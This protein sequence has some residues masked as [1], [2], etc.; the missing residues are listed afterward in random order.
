MVNLAK[1][2]FDRY[3]EYLGDSF[4]V[5]SEHI[6][7]P[8]LKER[9]RRWQLIREYMFLWNLDCL[10]IWGSDA[11]FSL[12][13]ANFRYVTALPSTMGRSLCVFPRKG[14]PVAF[15]GTP[16]DNY[17]SVCYKWVKNVRPFASAKDVIG[18]INDLGMAN[19]RIGFVG[20]MPHYWPFVL[21][22]NVW[23]DIQKGL[24]QA[25]F[26][27]S[28]AM[29]W[30]IQIIKSD[31]EIEFLRKAGQIASNVY[32]ALLTAMK[33]GVRE[34]EIFAEMLRAMVANGA[35]STGMILLDTGNP[36]FPHPKHPPVS[37]RPIKSGDMAIT[38]FHTKYAGFHTH[39]ERTVALGT[40]SEQAKDLF[41]VGLASYR[42]GME[43]MKPGNTLKDACAALRA[44]VREARVTFCECGFHSHGSTSGGFP[45]FNENEDDYEDIQSVLI[46]ENMVF[47]NQIDLYDPKVKRG[48]GIVLADSFVITKDGPSMLANI[49]LEIAVV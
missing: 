42:A 49:P 16:H 29:L 26:I 46:K 38:E 17:E 25:N 5:L 13:E 4:P 40:L 37:L 23:S 45:G 11:Q 36:V 9:D 34:C 7:Q 30:H 6:P 41:A 8:S 2:P 14:E 18:I 19:G 15:V 3:R 28:A 27:D 1:T 47:T 12:C 24:P 33:P 21:Q 31:E 43:K 32:D 10:L 48:H 35:E 39:T 22:Y 20:D 44:P